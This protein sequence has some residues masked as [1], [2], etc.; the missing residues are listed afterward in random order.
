[1]I[2]KFTGLIKFNFEKTKWSQPF[3]LLLGIFVGTEFSLYEKTNIVWYYSV[4]FR[5]AR[6]IDVAAIKHHLEKMKRNYEIHFS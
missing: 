6:V 5:T 2:K 3:H 4:I 1:M